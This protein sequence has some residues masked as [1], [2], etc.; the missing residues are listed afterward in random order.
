MKSRFSTKVPGLFVLFIALFAFSVSCRKDYSKEGSPVPEKEKLNG[1]TTTQILRNGNAQTS[2]VKF[3]IDTPGRKLFYTNTTTGIITHE[4]SFTD[5]WKLNSVLQRLFNAVRIDSFERNQNGKINRH[6]VL[7]ANKQLLHEFMISEDDL[8]DS[9]RL[10]FRHTLPADPSF[11][12]G[13]QFY[14]VH[15]ATQRILSFHY[16]SKRKGTDFDDSTRANSW[17]QYSGNDLMVET[18]TQYRK[19]TGM[20]NE[21]S[22]ALLTSSYQSIGDRGQLQPIREL[23]KLIFGN[24]LAW[25][26]RG[27]GWLPTWKGEETWMQPGSFA[28]SRAMRVKSTLN[29]LPN[30]EELYNYQFS[31]EKNAGN[32]ITEIKGILNGGMGDPNETIQFK[33]NFHY[34]KE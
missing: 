33:T 10:H 18:H 28:A 12:E 17:F 1:W 2:N 8:G 3:H 27:A 13:E 26:R 31:F 22:S 21:T 16:Y 5:N 11:I 30:G 32:N 29:G 19:L 7:G 4:F 24:E 14:I 34:V 23:E 15:K 25:L 9:I 20:Q 6:L